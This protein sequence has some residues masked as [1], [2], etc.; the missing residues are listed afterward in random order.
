MIKGMKKIKV[1]FTFVLF[2]EQQNVLDIEGFEEQQNVHN[3]FLLL[4]KKIIII[5]DNKKTL[6]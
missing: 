6:L 4:T 5:T 3:L 1:I 2:K